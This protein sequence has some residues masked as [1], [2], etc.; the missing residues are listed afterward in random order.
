[1]RARITL[2][3]FATLARE[4]AVGWYRDGAPSM[5]A[6]LAFYTLFSMAPLLLLAIS[7][8]GIA[9]GSD[10]ARGL[11]I[12]QLTRLMGEQGATAVSSV[13][14]A[15]DERST[16]VLAAL[17]SLATLV[18]GAITVFMELRRDLDRIW[19]FEPK[20]EKGL[21]RFVRGHVFSVG[22]VA[23]I[24][25]LL[26]V[27]LVVSATVAA[28]GGLWAEAFPGSGYVMRAGEFLG[29]FLVI[30][31][32]F[33]MIYRILPSTRMAWSDLWVGAAVTSLLFWIGKWLIGLYLGRSAVTSPFGAA[34][35][36][37][38]VILWVY[39]SAQVFFLGAEFTR[40]YALK[41]GSLS[42]AA[43]S[44]AAPRSSA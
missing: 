19:R 9:I 13:L 23:S 4:A 21:W 12:D 16:G 34:G 40:A 20:P 6:A 29:S 22:M 11:V 33:A 35:A 36:L 27:S 8:A 10:T 26:M 3:Q 15:A 37:I 1:M 41:F 43:D 28:I 38:I 17:T 14:R 7:I 42:G 44:A 5:G 30:T 31:G 18:L 32:L 25:F 39:Y 24:G 2:R